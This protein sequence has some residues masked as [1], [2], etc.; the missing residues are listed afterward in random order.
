MQNAN[1]LEF[2]LNDGQSDWDHPSPYGEDSG[3]K[4]YV[5]SSPGIWRLKNG[6]LSKLE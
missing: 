4:N 1:Y 2:V 5:A 6:K 3:Q